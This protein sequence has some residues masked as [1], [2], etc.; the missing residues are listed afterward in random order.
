MGNSFRGKFDLDAPDG[1][2]GFTEIGAGTPPAASR[3]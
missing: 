1:S 3:R 2:G